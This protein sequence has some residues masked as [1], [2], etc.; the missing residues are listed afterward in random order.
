LSERMSSPVA[1]M[2]APWRLQNFDAGSGMNTE[3]RRL[4]GELSIVRGTRGF[5]KGKTES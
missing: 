3:A 4:A 5:S 2:R 1:G